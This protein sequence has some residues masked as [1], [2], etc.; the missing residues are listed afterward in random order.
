MQQLINNP[1]LQQVLTDP[2]E[3]DDWLPELERFLDRDM[4][5][6]RKSVGESAIK[7]MQR[8]LIFLGYSTTARGGFNIDGDFGRGTNR[9]I[10]QFQY[11]NNL[12]PAITREMLAY[13]CSWNTAHSKI[14]TIPDAILNQQTLRKMLETAIQA[15]DNNTVL[16]GNFEEA[17]TQLN[18]LH[19]KK[20]LNCKRILSKYGNL[21]TEAA[22]KIKSAQ[23]IIVLPQWILAIIRQETSGIVRPRFEQHHFSKYARQEPGASYPDLRFRSMSF[24]LGQILGSNYQ[25]V[26]ASSP[27][28]MYISP[29][30]EQVVFVG[31]FLAKKPRVV[32]K[33]NPNE[34]DFH[35]LARYY[36]GPGYAKHHYHESLQRWFNEFSFLLKT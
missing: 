36:N 5:L 32:S 20:Y 8:L 1:Q 25:R 2:S 31:R 30:L 14:S 29:L 35:I 15:I 33:T 13:P 23:G 9:G 34:Q 18:A 17:I 11:E 6:T 7:A 21:A 28:N 26:R 27:K 19:S 16:C 22:E 12:N 4:A 24:G 3:P 10:A